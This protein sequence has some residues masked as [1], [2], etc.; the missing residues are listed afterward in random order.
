LNNWWFLKWNDEEKNKAQGEGGSAL[1]DGR[2]KDRAESGGSEKKG[3]ATKTASRD[4]KEK[5]VI[6]ALAG[7]LLLIVCLP[8]KKKQQAPDETKLDNTSIFNSSDVDNVGAGTMSGELPGGQSGGELPGGQGSGELAGGGVSGSAPAREL[9]AYKESMERELEELLSC[10]E[11]VGKVKVMITLRSS[12]EEIV[13]KDRPSGRS[14]VTEQ[15]AAGGSR[16]T[17][18]LDSQEETV[19]VIDGEGRQ[20]PYVRKIMQPDVEGVAVLAQGGGDGVVRQNI[21]EAIQ[22]L[23]DIEANK[24][25]IAKMKTTK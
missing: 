22:A 4:R 6:F 5:F 1:T 16:S 7:L 19:F 20:I 25:K 18:D 24:I 11:G 8:V 13:E 2:G 3:S 14:S 23:F 12:G 21:S 15:D 9:E 17:N 10:M